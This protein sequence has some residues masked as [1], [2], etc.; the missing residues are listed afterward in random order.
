MDWANAKVRPAKEWRP[1]RKYK[2]LLV[3]CSC[4]ESLAEIRGLN[5]SYHGIMN[6]AA[7][8]ATMR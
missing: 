4:E 5:G 8:T 3:K 2:P 7:E 1:M 6:Q